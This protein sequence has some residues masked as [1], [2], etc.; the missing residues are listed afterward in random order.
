VVHRDVPAVHAAAAGR[1]RAPSF[2]GITGG[3]DVARQCAK[4]DTNMKKQTTRTTLKLSKQTISN[5]TPMQLEAAGGGAINLST[6]C[7]YTNSCKCD[8]FDCSAL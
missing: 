3:T 7:R 8:S 4:E 5:L 2:R 6:P 1:A